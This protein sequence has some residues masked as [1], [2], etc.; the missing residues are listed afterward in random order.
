MEDAETQNGFGV[1]VKYDRG[2]AVPSSPMSSPAAVLRRW[3]W[4]LIVALDSI[5]RYM[6][7][8]EFPHLCRSKNH[9]YLVTSKSS[10]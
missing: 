6:N 9:M 10:W 5:L 8:K 2:L 4:K 3:V 7:E 1:M